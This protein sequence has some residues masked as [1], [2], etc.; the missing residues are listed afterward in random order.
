MSYLVPK[1]SLKKN[2]CGTIQLIAGEIVSLH[3]FPNCICL[4]VNIIARLEFEL[5]YC[6]IAIQ[7]VSHYATETLP[8]LNK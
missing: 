3:N 1:Q 7:H 5:A 6:D 2:S 4:K 8:I